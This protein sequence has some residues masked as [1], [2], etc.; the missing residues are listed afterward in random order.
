MSGRPR[1]TRKLKQWM[2]EQVDGGQC[3]GLVWEDRKL[4]MFRIPWK[5]A[6]KQDY[7]HDEDAA[8]FKA[9]AKFKGKYKEGDKVDPASWKTR[10][11]CALNKSS[12]FEEV[13]QR[14]QLDISEPYKVY[15]IIEGNG[16]KR[17]ASPTLSLDSVKVKQEKEPRED[18]SG[19]TSPV[20]PGSGPKAEENDSG[21]DPSSGSEMS[22][23][24]DGSNES[25]LLGCSLNPTLEDSTNYLIS[26]VAPMSPNIVETEPNAMFV[27]FRYGSVE[28]S[29]AVTRHGCKISSVV[30]RPGGESSFGSQALEK[31]CFPP[32]SCVGDPVK[33]RATEELLSFLERGLMLDSNA[34]GIFAQR[35]CQGRVFWTGPGASQPGRPNK[36]ERDRV[37]KLFD[38]NVFEEELERYRQGLGVLP[39]HQ[40]TL[41]F[42]EELSDS[43][44]TDKKLITVQ[45][46]QVAAK[47]LLDREL[48]IQNASFLLLEPLTGASFS[49][50][51]QQAADGLF[52]IS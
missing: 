38:R 2:I 7:R 31:L 50:A 14:S 9:W 13:P 44:T 49:H 8:I 23:Q 42:G 30:P 34:H 25:T 15:R 17:K 22:A 12:E 26:N 1:S 52:G 29:S 37:E 5:H 4:G 24:E 36:L 46:H 51:L 18:R 39:Q 3:P 20:L 32:A 10:M 21:C 43:E 19:S 35:L 41:C 11:R 6:G 45:V 47:R 48:E 27:S 28:V 40:V 16:E 33:R